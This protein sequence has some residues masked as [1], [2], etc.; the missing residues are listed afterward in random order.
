[1]EDN[2]MKQLWR[3]A[4]GETPQS[5]THRVNSTLELA[6]SWRFIR[7]LQPALAGALV[8]LLLGSAVALE[9]LGLLDSL[10]P[11]LRKSLLPQANQ[12]VEGAIPQ[13]AKQ[14]A[15]ARFTVEEAAY[16]GH[17][18]YLT[19]QVKPAD[20][21]KTLLMDIQAEPAWAYDWHLTGDSSQGE[22]FAERAL[23]QEQILVQAEVWNA[24]VNEN[25]QQVQIHNA[26]YQEGDLRYTL[27]FPAQGEKVQ[28]QLNLLAPNIYNQI[29]DSARG[30]LTF[31][32]TKSP[33]IQ[34]YTAKLPISLPKA[35][36]EL[37]LCQVETTPIASYLT[38]RY[39]LLSDATPLQAVN[40]QDGIW[41]DWVDETGRPRDSGDSFDR[42]ETLPENGVELVK[43]FGALKS[44]PE[45]VTLT[46]YNGMSKE[47][48]DHITLALLPKEEQ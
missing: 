15:L 27:S 12:M 36:L 23:S 1:M 37:T 33:P 17:Q 9:R 40:M 26:Q 25:P 22:S 43:S 14:P 45:N 21:K 47:R 48:F 6:S 16:D 28:V 44:T 5:F 4:C 11:T 41:V 7:R 18:V 39:A 42:L 30:T 13:E 10:N 2:H 3:E 19:L 32:L 46:F 20:P 31:T 35:G 29:D 34:V 38:L 8:L 24:L